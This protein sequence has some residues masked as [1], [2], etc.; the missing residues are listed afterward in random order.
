M[1]VIQ[2][3]WVEKPRKKKT[4]DTAPAFAQAAYDI[5]DSTGRPMKRFSFSSKSTMVK[6]LRGVRK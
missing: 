6:T 4:T 1:P 5:V 3:K 2:N